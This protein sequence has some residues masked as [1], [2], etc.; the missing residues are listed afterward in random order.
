MIASTD[1]PGLPFSDH[2]HR[3]ITSDRAPGT[4]ESAEPLLGIDPP[5]DRA[6]ILLDECCSGIERVD[7]GN[8]GEEALP[9]S[10]P[11]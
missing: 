11:E 8:V 7:A 2:V 5:F 1:P 9:S 6:M 10:W 4:S 3:L